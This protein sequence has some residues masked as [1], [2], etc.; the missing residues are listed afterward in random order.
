MNADHTEQRLSELEIQVT[1]QNQTI[2]SLNEVVVRQWSEID[3]LS[4]QVKVLAEQVLSLEDE[5][6]PHKV[7]R[8]PHY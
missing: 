8:P 7:T 2:D 1:Q 6:T 4:R 5:A 3:R